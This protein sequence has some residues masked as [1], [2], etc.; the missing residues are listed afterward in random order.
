MQIYCIPRRAGKSATRVFII[1]YYVWIFIFPG[2]NSVMRPRAKR[3]TP[4]RI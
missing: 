1:Y 2:D 3:V 4:R